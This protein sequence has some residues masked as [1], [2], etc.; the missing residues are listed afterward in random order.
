MGDYL[1]GFTEISAFPFFINYMLIDTA[2]CNI[3]GLGGKDVKEAFVVAK[4]EICFGSI[5]G[6]I[7]LTVLI[8]I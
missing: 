4:I 7:T 6:Y 2:C 3:V 8:R 5:F 1:Y